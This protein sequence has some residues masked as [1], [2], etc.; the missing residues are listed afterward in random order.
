VK[1]YLDDGLR[2]Y[3]VINLFFSTADPRPG[4]AV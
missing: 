3:H 4:D 1:G 2:Y